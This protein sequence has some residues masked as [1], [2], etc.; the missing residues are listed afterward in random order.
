M[1]CIEKNRKIYEEAFQTYGDD[2]RSCLW[3]K[4]MIMR[5]QELVKIAP[6]E[7]TT[8][9][10]IGCGIGGFYEYM[11]KDC[12]IKNLSYKGV[13]LIEGMVKLAS[14]KYPEASFET[15][16]IFENPLVGLYDY[17]F[18]CGVFNIAVAD[19]E[20]FMKRMLKEA[21]SYCKKGLAFNFISSY[22]NFQNEETAYYN[23]QDIFTFCIE[24]LSR[25]IKIFH[26]YEKCD[27]S[28][29]VYK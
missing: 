2:T 24:N 15:R 21:F 14:Q 22:V 7:G 25:K 6:L 1:N 17:V 8:V 11:V 10:D 16:N 23:P 20:E 12:D 4:P 29:F 28:V 5:Y 13:D 3:D 19:S 27:V 9:L 26:H 18:L